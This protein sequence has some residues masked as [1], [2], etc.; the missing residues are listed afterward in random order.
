MYLWV[1]V[2]DEC[3]ARLISAPGSVLAAAAFV[4]LL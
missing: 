2:N 1:V 4:M 3:P